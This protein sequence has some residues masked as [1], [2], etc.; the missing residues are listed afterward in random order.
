MKKCPY[1]GKEYA[2]DIERC[3]IDDELLLSEEV[4]SAKETIA[5]PILPAALPK[6]IFSERQMSVIELV[7]VC[8]IAFGG[9]ILASTY[10]YF[11][12]GYGSS[13]RSVYSWTV[14][15]LHEGSS[16]GLLWY[17]LARQGKSLK[18]LG[19]AWM[20]KDFGWSIILGFAGSLAFHGIYNA[21]YFTGLTSTTYGRSS[22]HVGHVLFS[23]G[24]FFSTV[25]IQFLNPFFEELIVRAYLMTKIKL[26]TNS[27]TKA[28]IISTLLQ[29]SYHFYQGAPAAFGHA[30]TF[31]IFSIYYA[32]T[33]RIAPVILAHLYADVGGTLWYIFQH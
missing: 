4:P 10:S 3:L 13:G 20:W 2:D 29:T 24:I 26:L 17:I 6:I 28:I 21:I 5:E 33:N 32:K 9:S 15:V 11:D 31:L 18:D 14:Q 30:A 12:S 22:A 8:T 25:L 7:L 27:A 23:G 16:L 19:L 1:C